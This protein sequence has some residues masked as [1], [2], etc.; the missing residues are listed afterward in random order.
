[1]ALGSVKSTVFLQAKF[2]VSVLDAP[3]LKDE[4]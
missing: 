2:A 3:K 4:G 1:M